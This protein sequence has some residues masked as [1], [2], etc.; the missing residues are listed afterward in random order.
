MSKA[1]KLEWKFYGDE[2]KTPLVVLHGLLGSSR[3]WATVA[4]LLGEHFAVFTLDLR[5]HGVSPH[6]ESM[7]YEDMVRDVEAWVEERGLKKF[8]LLGHSLGGKAA[9]RYACQH[10]DRLLGLVVEDIA[11]KTYEVRYSLEFELMNNLDLK[12]AQSRLEIDNYFAQKIT[13]LEWRQ[14]LLTN[15]IRDK[16]S[17]AFLWAVNLPVL[18][19]FLP[20]IMQNSLESGDKYLGPVLFLKGEKSDFIVEGDYPAIKE[21]FPKSSIVEIHNA[22]HNLHIDNVPLFIENIVNFSR[23]F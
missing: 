1:V 16:E 15:L 9:M 3:N 21:Y 4:R 6:A 5:N 17:K 8:F 11:P 18:T 23:S 12:S 14:F 7:F 13:N 2:G 20:H 19:A 22:G 10:G